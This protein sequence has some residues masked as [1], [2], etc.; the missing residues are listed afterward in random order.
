MAKAQKNDVMEIN[1]Y[2][3]ENFMEPGFNNITK[4]LTLVKI[5]AMTV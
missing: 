3:H 1:V 4:I 2:T 5:T